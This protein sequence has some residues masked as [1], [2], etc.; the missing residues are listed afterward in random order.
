MLYEVITGSGYTTQ[1][2]LLRFE[3]PPTESVHS[4]DDSIFYLG[5]IHIET[6]KSFRISLHSDFFT[7]TNLVFRFLYFHFK[8]RTFIFFHPERL[9]I[10]AS[11]NCKLTVQT[12]IGQHK[13]TRKR[14]KI[15]RFQ[16]FGRITS[17]NVCYTKL[18]RIILILS[19]IC[20]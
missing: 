6:C 20:R 2:F 11:T 13:L 16:F 1:N 10:V 12:I 7:K 17:Y 18:L 14:S 19:R 15:V 8:S 4:S 9:R 5:I 3:I